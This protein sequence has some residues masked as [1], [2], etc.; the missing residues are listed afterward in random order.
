MKHTKYF[1]PFLVLGLLG[2]GCLSGNNAVGNDGGVFWTEDA[3]ASWTQSADLPTIQGVTS[4]A[5]VNVTSLEV[6]PSD[7]SV[8]YVGTRANGL[9]YTTDNGISWQRPKGVEGREGA[10]LDIEV[11]PNDVCTAYLLKLDKIIKTDDCHRS[12]KTLTVEKRADEQFTTFVL[13]W[14]NTQILWA[15]NTAGDIMKSID[16]GISWTTVE[17]VRNDVTA[18]AVSNADSRIVFVGTAG[19]GL[20]R[21][22]DGGITWE[23]QED[24]LKNEFRN[25]DNIFSFAQSRDGSRVIMNTEYGLLNS[26]DRGVTWQALTLRHAP[27]EI[28]IWDVAIHPANKDVISYGTLGAI[29]I[30]TDGGNAWSSESLPSER[31]PMALLVHPTNTARLI[32]GFSTYND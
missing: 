1:L 8:W 12:Y 14:F 9:F 26:F 5:G 6:D 28:R 17:R 22:P 24:A 2:Q 23:E 4:M 11:D 19:R 25:S 29:Y 7:S 15:G 31:A 30:S 21:S 3:G 10:V 16:G 18:I 13:D 20:W 32:V 27:G